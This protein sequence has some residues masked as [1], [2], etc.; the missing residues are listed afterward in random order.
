MD[1]LCPSLVYTRY[2]NEIYI[3]CAMNNCCLAGDISKTLHEILNKLSLAGK[4]QTIE[5]GDEP[6]PCFGGHIGVSHKDGRIIFEYKEWCH[7]G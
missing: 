2:V 5:V 4:M 3:S 6:V 1:K 7:H